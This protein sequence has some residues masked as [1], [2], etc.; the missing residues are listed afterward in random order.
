MRRS[1][2]AHSP[3]AA[4]QSS[5]GADVTAA[6]GAAD[7]AE[8]RS[9]SDPSVAAG[10]AGTPLATRG[11]RDLA[12]HLAHTAE[13]FDRRL[14][15]G[16]QVAEP[17]DIDQFV[18]FRRRGRAVR[19]AHELERLGYTT[20]LSRLGFRRVL[21]ISHRAPVDE[22]TTTGFLTT[23]IGIVEAHGGEYDGWRARLV[24][25]H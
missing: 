24:P 12:W 10:T 2:C 6:D 15:N 7:A 4:P 22:T 13:Q 16:D 19:A 14:R 3:N 18:V 1:G 20:S 17:R 5:S 9:S 8:A 11:R 23:V 25:A 21:T